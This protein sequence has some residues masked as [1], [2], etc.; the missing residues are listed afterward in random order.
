MAIYKFGATALPVC[1]T[2][3]ECGLHPISET[4]FEHA[5]AAPKISASSSIIFQFSGPFKPRPADTITSASER[6][7]F[8]LLMSFPVIF[9]SD[10][11]VF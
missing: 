8:P 4:G 2:C 11:V 9:K 1:P 3:S 7:I 6:D 10:S 5:V